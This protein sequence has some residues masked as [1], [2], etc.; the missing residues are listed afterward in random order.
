MDISAVIVSWNVREHLDRCLR[1]VL[2]GSSDPGVRLREVVVVDNA[3]EDGSADWVGHHFPDVRLI[4]NRANLGFAAACNQGFEL[5]T[6]DAILLI[7]PDAALAPGALGQLATALERHPEAGAV[8]PQILGS[9][10][11]VLPTRRS[12]PTL[13]TGF[14]ESTF[15]QDHFPNLPHLGRFYRE[16]TP[17]STEQEADWLVGAC[18]LIRQ[19]AMQEIGPLDP[20]FFMYFEE[21]DWF[22]RA[23]AAGWRAWYVPGARVTHHQG[24]SSA[25]VPHLAHLYFTRSKCAY[26]AK[27]HGPLAG[28][29]VHGFLL[30]SYLLRAVE[31]GCK[32]LVGHRAAFRRKRIALFLSVLQRASRL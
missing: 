29:A 11:A 1:S 17:S 25:Q 27:H 10:G 30:L 19:T 20:R 14:I 6:G 8:G 22:L 26:Y 31:D 7:N 32:L 24:A 5:A 4:A 23:R 12:F 2:S 13:A 21:V 28:R 18:L 3:S 16:G 15:I 9:D